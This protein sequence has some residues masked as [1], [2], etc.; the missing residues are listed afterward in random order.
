MTIKKYKLL[1]DEWSFTC[2]RMFVKETILFRTIIYQDYT[3]VWNDKH[4][5]YFLL[6]DSL[7]IEPEERK[8]GGLDKYSEYFEKIDISDDELNFIKNKYKQEIEM[9]EEEINKDQKK[10]AN[11]INLN[12]SQESFDRLLN[13]QVEIKF[14][15][16]EIRDLL[17]TKK[18]VND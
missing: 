2:K 7:F 18:E 6:N 17:K 3:V 10:D 8:T 16:E 4:P 15:L 5:N 14:L 12:I 13:Y 1:K 11:S 9:I